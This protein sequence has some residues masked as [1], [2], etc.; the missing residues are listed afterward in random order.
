MDNQIIERYQII[1]LMIFAFLSWA[2]EKQMNE[3]KGASKTLFPV[4]EGKLIFEYVQREKN[5]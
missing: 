4:Y 3:N 5:T 2:W 1:S